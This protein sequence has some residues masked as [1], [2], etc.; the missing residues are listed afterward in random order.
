MLKR[1]LVT[2][3]N[4]IDGQERIATQKAEI[5]YA[6]LEEHPDTYRVV[7]E[8]ASRSRMNICFRVTVTEDIETSEAEFLRIAEQ[9]GLTGLKGHRSV[10]GIRASNVSNSGSYF[11]LVYSV[12]GH[13][14]SELCLECPNH[15]Q[16]V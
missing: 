13:I 10:G 16:T 2:F 11:Y 9:R 8:K 15:R 3:P 12:S 7:P 6:A 14:S 4:H 5:I 1:L